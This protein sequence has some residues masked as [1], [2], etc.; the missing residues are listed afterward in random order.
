M[1]HL[2]YATAVAA[3]IAIPVALQT[4]VHA[5]PA[6]TK[7][8]DA[9]RA[10]VNTYCVSCHSTALKTG[11]LALDTL[12]LATAANDA[13]VWE[14]VLRKLRGHQMPPPGTPQPAQKDVDAFVS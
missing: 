4:Q 12:N 2:I 11:G 8:P 7:A 14:K 10:L 13:Q 9:R 1:K 5:Q 3:A 6:A